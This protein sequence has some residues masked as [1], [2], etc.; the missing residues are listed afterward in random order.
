MI[1]GNEIHKMANVLGLEEVHGGYTMLMFSARIASGLP[2]RSI[3]RVH[4]IVAPRYREFSTLII[5]KQT[6][7]R[8]R[9]KREP[10]SRTESERL[11]RIARVWSMAK[12]VYKD[13]DLARAFLSRPHQML[14]GR[15]P[16]EV[17]TE[18]EYGA[19]AV[20]EILGR[21]KYGSAA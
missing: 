16:L 8:R 11:A 7:G 18:T 2:L 17:A 12:D 1:H 3:E 19:D 4:K 13:E 9:K 10:L 14:Q 20:V 15:V 21:L 5:T 6:L